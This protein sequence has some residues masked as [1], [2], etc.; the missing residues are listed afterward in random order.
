[1]HSQV[2]QLMLAIVIMTIVYFARWN[3]RR[4]NG[5][6]LGLIMVAGLVLVVAALVVNQALEI[7]ATAQWHFINQ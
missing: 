2:F 3:I 7:H 4:H 6:L 1:M 5:N